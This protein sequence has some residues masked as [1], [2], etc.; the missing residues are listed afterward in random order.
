M[1]SQLISYKGCLH[2]WVIEVWHIT[3]PHKSSIPDH[4]RGKFSAC[5]TAIP[6]RPKPHQQ[7][8][9][10]TW[11]SISPC[12][13]TS[14]TTPMRI[15]SATS[16]PSTTSYAPS[17]IKIK[18]I[19]TSIFFKDKASTDSNYAS[20]TRI[21]Q[22]HPKTTTNL[23]Q[24]PNLPSVQS[25][26]N[27]NECLCGLRYCQRLSP[28]W[29]GPSWYVGHLWFSLHLSW[30]CRPCRRTFFLFFFFFS[31]RRPERNTE[32]SSISSAITFFLVM[33]DELSLLP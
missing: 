29:I 26:T 14:I 13:T 21:L 8:W 24:N 19:T 28:S 10:T 2:A 6:W 12:T 31:F 9:F 23:I 7:I 22:W 17:T 20:P 3:P 25:P 27:D 5:P 11:N 32:A 33:C 18:C 15:T 16:N 1:H 30:F 4:K